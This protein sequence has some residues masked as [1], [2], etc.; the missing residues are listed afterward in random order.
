[1]DPK[2]EEANVSPKQRTSPTALGP[3]GWFATEREGP[4]FGA[5]EPSTWLADA[6]RKTPRLKRG[7]RFVAGGHSARELRYYYMD[8]RGAR[9]FWLSRCG[10][11]ASFDI[12]PRESQ[13]EM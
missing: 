13:K 7:E 1:M 8:C 10:A 11:R 2:F 3:R 4:A 5:M 12:K 9:V 6:G